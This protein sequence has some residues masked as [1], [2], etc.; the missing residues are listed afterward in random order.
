MF[1]KAAAYNNLIVSL[2]YAGFLAIWIWARDSLHST[3]SRIVA[4]LLGFSLL[5]FVAFNLLTSFVVSSR[6]IVLAKI[7]SRTA[8]PCEILED[9]AR[10]RVVDGHRTLKYY[11]AWYW[12][13]LLSATTGFLAGLLLL[14]LVGLQIFGFS[15]GLH[16]VFTHISIL[17]GKMF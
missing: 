5:L 7:L 4:F 6:N 15:F 8:E 12:V 3:D 9:I 16:S 13:F 11:A 2:G 17:A 10:F 1:D 14:V